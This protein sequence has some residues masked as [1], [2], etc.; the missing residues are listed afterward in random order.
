MKT[1]AQQLKDRPEKNKLIYSSQNLSNQPEP[2]HT[3][4]ND[5]RE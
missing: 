5:C 4:N 3:E 1:V 2:T